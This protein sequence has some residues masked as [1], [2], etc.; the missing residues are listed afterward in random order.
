MKA[1]KALPL[2]ALIALAAAPVQ[3]AQ[4]QCV[5]LS[6]I[7]QTPAID[8]S[9]V[10]IKLR[11]RDHYMRMDLAGRC[12]GLKFNGFAHET[13]L[14]ELCTSDQLKVIEP[15]GAICVIDKIV[16]ISPDE[17][18]ALLQRKP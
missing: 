8:E 10:L 17:A 16:D 9:T 6:I 2:A 12:P 11:G 15:V 5:S 14:N 1:M 7:D 3:A 13:R 4:H 18:H